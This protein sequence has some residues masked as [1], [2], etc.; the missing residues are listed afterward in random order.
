MMAKINK[1]DFQLLDIRVSVYFKILIKNGK[2]YLYIPEE[3]FRKHQENLSASGF[4]L[5]F[6]R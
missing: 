6:I 5:G 4:D 3:N 1:I 2:S